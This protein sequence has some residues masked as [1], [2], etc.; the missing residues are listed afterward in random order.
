MHGRERHATI[1]KPAH[2]GPNRFGDIEKLQ[3]DEHLLPLSRKPIDEAEEPVRHEQFQADLVKA[4][5]VSE[6][7]HQGLRL[8]DA[9]DV[10][11][12]D[13]AFG[14][15]D[16]LHLRCHGHSRTEDSNGSSPVVF[17]Q[18]SEGQV[19]RLVG[20]RGKLLQELFQGFAA[21]LT[22]WRF[23]IQDE[24]AVDVNHQESFFVEDH[25]VAFAGG[26]R[27]PAARNQAFE[28]QL[29]LIYRQ[30][31][32]LSDFPQIEK[33][34]ALLSSRENQKDRQHVAESDSRTAPRRGAQYG[35]IRRQRSKQ[36]TDHDHHPGKIDPEEKNRDHGECPVDQRISRDLGDVEREASLHDLE[37]QGRDHASDQSVARFDRAVRYEIVEQRERC[38]RKEEGDESENRRARKRALPGESEGCTDEVRGDREARADQDRPENC[39]MYPVTT[40]PAFSGNMFASRNAWM[41]SPSPEKIGNAAMSA[42]VIVTRGTSASKVV[43]VT[44]EANCKQR[45]SL[46]RLNTCARK[47][48]SCR[49]GKGMG[50][51]NR[52]VNVSYD[53]GALTPAG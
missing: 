13:K 50:S 44:L 35:E 28:D 40:F 51:L 15:R 6:A 22:R 26:P 10:Q 24:L 18:A 36:C 31:C 2:R 32:V 41:C 14:T 37:R 19:Q 23:A 47:R 46:N 8:F 52:R 29:G 49:S 38:T 3:I 17:K 34:R 16:R 20:A 33:V 4:H 1:A 21:L 5:A 45:A 25:C 48:P 42:S 43:K 11:G 27:H 7:L 53:I 9:C 12:R 30:R 39:S